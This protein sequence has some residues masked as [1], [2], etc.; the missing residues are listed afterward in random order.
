[1]FK[2]V[3]RYIIGMAAKLMLATFVIGVLILTLARLIIILKLQ[4]I[5]DQDLTTIAQLLGYFMPNYFGFMLPF[6]LFWACY[7]VTRQLS[8]NS[9]IRA[10]TAA[11]ISQKRLVFP[12]IFIALTTVMVNMAVYG[13]LEPLA[14]YQY[15]ALTHRI[16]NTAAY[17]TIQAGV[18]MKAGHRTVFVNEIN[19]PDKTFRGLLIYENSPDGKLREV[20]A[21]RGRLVMAGNDSVL[22]LEEGNRIQLAP[23]NPEAPSLPKPEENLNFTTLDIPLVADSEKFHQRGKDEEE[24]TVKELVERRTTPPAGVT[25]S[26]MTVQLNH[27]LIVILTALILPFLAIAMAQ[28]GPRGAHYLKGPIAFLFVIAYQQLVEFG[29]VF[30]ISHEISPALALW[31]TFIIMACISVFAFLSLDAPRDNVVV[32]FFS[33]LFR[34]WQGYLNTVTDRLKP[35]GSW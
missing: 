5:D 31:P 18:F 16:T 15:R 33:N 24:L 4:A 35:K 2:L 28:S 21:S 26:A 12:F 27:K 1:M 13:W 11:G 25:E 22:R 9:E 17:L 30:A 20:I 34:S 8:G 6:A 7:M 29:K 10:F 3:D 14:R 23:V 32:M 19:K